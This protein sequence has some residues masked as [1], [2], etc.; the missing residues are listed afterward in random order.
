MTTT[1]VGTI[2]GLA[3]N[4]QWQDMIDQ[5]MTQEQAR[6][7]D[8]ITA[9]I[10]ADN[11]SVTS[12]NTYSSLATAVQTAATTLRDTAFTGMRATGGTTTTGQAAL[13]A[14]AT[15]GATP[16]TYSAEVLSLAT[17]DKL[18]GSTAGSATAPLGLTGEFFVNGHR[19][20]LA[21]SD[22]LS[23]VRDKINAVNTA[24]GGSGVSASILTIGSSANR[25]V[26][27][28]ASAGA[29]GVQLIDGSSGVLSS[30]G[31]VD[32][33]AATTVTA[34]GGAQ[35]YR[36]G[37]GTAVISTQLGMTTT[38]AAADI[39]VGN[40]TV[41]VDLATDSL[42][43]IRGK[44]VAAGESATLASDS[45]NGQPF[46]RLDVGAPVSA[47]SGDAASQKIVQA[48]GFSTG[49]TAVAQVLSE[50][51]AWTDAA[52]APVTGAT[53]LADLH[54]GAKA[55]GIAAGDSIV[56]TGTRGDGVPV[57]RTITLSGGETVQ[58]VLD[59]PSSSSFFGSPTRS[60][61]VSID[62]SGTLQVTD[63]TAGDSQLSLSMVVRK[64]DGSTAGLGQMTTSTT[65]YARELVAGSDA[66]VRIDGTLITRTTNSIS[67]AVAGVTL[68]LLQALPGSRATITVAR[69]TSGITSSVN[70]FVQ[71]YNGLVSF[72]QSQ[73]SGTGPLAHNVTLRS[74][75]R[76]LTEGLIEQIPGVTG[77]YTHAAD[78]GLNLDKTGQLNLDS[79]ALSTAMTNNFAGVQALFAR[80]ATPTS[81]LSYLSDT[82]ATKPGT[83]AVS[84]SAAAS[85]AKFTGS[86][87][88]GTY[89]D[90]GTP[91]QLVVTD[92][93]LNTTTV[94][95][96]TG[97]D[98][99]AI[100]NRLNA[101]FAAKTMDA[102]AT[103][104]G[105]QLVI[106]SQSYGSSARLSVSAAAGGSNIASQLGI[107]GGSVGGVDVV[108]TID[109]VAA[110][111]NGQHLTGATGSSAE[112]LELM[113]NGSDPYT[114]SIAYS[115][116][117]AGLFSNVSTGIS[118]SGTGLVATTVDA[119]Q[120][121]ITTL[122]SRSADVQSHLDQH[123]AALTSQF[124]NME[125]ALA[126]LQAQ[127]AALTSQITSLQTSGG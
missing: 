112:G 20:S 22:T 4:V 110:T 21:N 55:V 64:A 29:S 119:L 47:V 12:W 108:G 45:F 122:T 101:S 49:R 41:H 2:Q 39:I 103:N 65:G 116:G 74:S 28:A 56:L 125:A 93:S 105:G 109:G 63:G 127:Q 97:D 13:S 59:A 81:G 84:V 36:F 24:T 58:N 42:D 9:Q 35:S 78:V 38:P 124:T 73:T 31:L 96:S 26:L 77:A 82:A 8:P 87:F 11:S 15:A 86:G 6:T 34:D 48:L 89:A 19:V 16:G 30:L 111:G 23:D 107:A 66:Q 14:T 27:T 79:G 60:A 83:Y 50:T 10:T 100:V 115:P 44:I 43:T 69:D 85:Q 46:S 7:L 91:D 104:V 113:Y 106:G 99:T 120:Q 62:P 121:Q 37:D 32:A 57:S 67:D 92:A 17:A 52:A 33:N 18:A 54:V 61:A 25:L 72:V 90:S 40:S 68:N 117:L 76:Q 5:I 94:S 75:L 53:A 114:G 3:S 80:V 88:G 70:S 95:L 51:S 102:I 98:I 126:K 1:P 118:Q 123:K 71:A